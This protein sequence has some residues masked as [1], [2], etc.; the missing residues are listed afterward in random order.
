M[1]DLIATAAFG[2]EAVVDRELERL[3]YD[4]RVV[5][6][7]K[8]TFA[9]DESGIARAN[10]WLRSADRV[11][12]QVG[13]FTAVDFGELFDRVEA[14]PWEEWLPKDG[15]IPVEVRAVRS[16]IKSPRSA[17]SI[18]KKAIVTRLGRAYGVAQLPESGPQYPVDVAV[19]GDDVTVAIDTSGDGLHKRGYRT[20]TGPAPLKETLA[21]ALIQLSYWRRDRPLADP[22]CGTGT[23]PIEAALIGRNI[24]PGL[25]RAFLAEDWPAL[26]RSIWNEA[27]A[28]AKDAIVK[29]PLAPILGTDI[30]PDSISRSKRHASAAGVGADLEFQICDVA[31]FGSRQEFGCLIANP[32]YG[33]R[34]GEAREVE[35]LYRTL[36]QVFERLPT[37]S[38]YVLTAH[39]DFERLVGRRPDRKRKLYNGRIECAYHQFY[40]PR[41][42][43]RT[44]GQGSGPPGV[45]ESR[46]RS[47]D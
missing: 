20:L 24:A 32:P 44:P 8:V 26:A 35:G 18:V 43:R 47:D 17:Q 3:G 27:R 31:Q 38:H 25:S 21:A 4:D 12:M 29:D 14:L 13:E 1:P 9:A 15:A 28:E 10:L 45:D 11:L 6:D 46:G 39:P 34:I 5:E 2:L 7:G 36:K 41:P 33:E 40:G 16:P 22:F 42:P 37:W 23:I 19:R 30:D